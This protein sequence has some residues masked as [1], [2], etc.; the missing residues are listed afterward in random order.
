M[1]EQ[2]D[3]ETRPAR[4]LLASRTKVKS[5]PS[6]IADSEASQR[7]KEKEK[8]EME[9]RL[10]RDQLEWEIEQN[11]EQIQ[12]QEKELHAVNEELNKRRQELEDE[13]DGE[14]GLQKDF[15]EEYHPLPTQQETSAKSQQLEQ[16]V[17]TS[18]KTTM[19]Y[20]QSAKT[21]PPETSELH[22]SRNP[23]NTENRE[24]QG[25]LERIRIPIFS[26]NKMD[27]QRWNAAFTSCVDMTSLYPQFK[28]LRLEACLAEEAA[29][30]IKGL[31][32]SLEAYEAAKARLF[33][34]YGGSRRQIQS[35]LE[36]LKKLQPIQD[37]NAKEL[38]TF[39]DLLE[40]A[41]ITLKEN[42]RNSDL[43]PGA[44]HTTILEKIPERLLSQYY[45][46]I[47]ENKYRDSLETL[48]DW[49][50]EEAAY[51]MQ[52]TEIKNGISIEDRNEPPRDGKHNFRRRS[53]S[54]FGDKSGKGK[55]CLCIGNHPLK[56]CEAFK[57]QSVDGRW[58]TMKRFGLCFRCLADNH[59]GKSCPLSKQ[60][61]INE[62][63][64]THQNLLH[65]DKAP[66]AQP[67]LRP[68]A[69]SYVQPLTTPLYSPINSNDRPR[70]TMEG[71]GSS[72]SVTMET[73][74]SQDR[75]QEVALRTVPVIL[76]NGSRRVFVNCLL[77]EGSDTT[78]VNEDVINELGL[79]GKKEPITVNVANDQTICFMSGTVEIGLESTD[80]RVDTKIIAKTSNKICGGLKAVNW[81]NIQGSWN[82]VRGI[83]FPRL[84]KGNRIDVL[85]GA[86]HYELMYSMKEVAGAPNEPCARLCPLGWTAIGKIQLD[87][88]DNH[89]TGFH[90][91]IRLQIEK[92]AR[93]FTLAE[94][95][96]TEL[97]GLLKRFWDLE[98][99]GITTTGQQ[100]L[101]PEDKLAWDKVNNYL[102]FD[103]Q[104]YEVAVL[105]RDERPQLPNNL[106]MAKKR[107][108]ST[109]RKLMKDKEIAVDY[110]Q[111]LKDYLNKKYIRRVP[112]KE[113]TPECQWLL[114]HFPV[115][116]P[117][118]ATSKVRIVFDGSAPF[119]GKSLNTEA[120]TGPKLQSDIFDILVKF[121]KEWVA[122]VGDISQMYHQLVLFPEDQPM[123]RFLWRNMQIN[124]ESEVYELRVWRLLLPV[125]RPIYLAEARRNPP[126]YLPSGSGCGKKSLLY[127]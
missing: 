28:M 70:A 59:H 88:K 12:R 66:T 76:K 52:A 97:N 123:H 96:T 5:R 81:V 2:I 58:Q 80:G 17:K 11:R 118:K 64:G 55:C 49:I 91:T 94:K 127:G 60:C 56:K 124:K 54:Y 57:K 14:L 105:W 32:Y 31:G 72:P 78:Y 9:A 27:F 92:G 4:L 104:H 47:D 48:K 68:E 45:R 119:E 39:A 87:T 84:A 100:H 36:E 15:F 110:Q 53:R 106:P 111:V 83:P 93:T 73:F 62:C 46:W 23:P 7:R 90:H 114:P 95:D 40:R 16:E 34:K 107:L 126:R 61:G 65:Y 10:R 30:T 85:L 75:Q 115:V 50:S 1:L 3:R 18:K 120:L 98:S 121:R 19:E 44:L 99:I 41:V 37:N 25:Q 42:N 102:K 117:E 29:N 109:E 122:L 13:I 116:R 112:D 67:P 82:H 113:P 51:Q 6:S 125:L 20:V 43:E 89:Y 77:D 71:N 22:R 33:R 24:T 35:H 26:G 21:P 103:G 108:V 69:E 74:G 63:K 79:T 86:D 38:E 8:A 101:T